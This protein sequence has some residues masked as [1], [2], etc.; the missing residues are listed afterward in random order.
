[1]E[2]L[3]AHPTPVEEL[4]SLRLGEKTRRYPSRSAVGR[5]RVNSSNDDDRE[6]PLR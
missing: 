3:L 5:D 6:S 4:R 2:P 1:M